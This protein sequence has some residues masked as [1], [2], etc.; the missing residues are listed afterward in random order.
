[1]PEVGTGARESLE[2]LA[3]MLP[4][5]LAAL[6][7]D[8]LVGFAGLAEE[9]GRHADALRLAVAGEIENRTDPS[10]GDDSLAHRLG[11][12][13]TAGALEMV[14]RTSADDA[15]RRVAEARNLAKL[16]VLG[17]AVNCGAL[18]RAQA[19]EIAA[20]ILK[21]LR[22]ADPAKVQAACEHLVELSAALPATAV[23]EAAKAWASALD[24]D[25]VEPEEKA[26]FEKRFVTLGKA[27][28]GMVKLTGLLTVEQAATIRTLTDAYLNPRGGV[29]FTPTGVEGDDAKPMATTGLDE[30][31]VD[32]RSAKQ[33]RA[34]IFHM[35]FAAQARAADAP[36]MGGAHPTIL[37][38][39]TR[40]NLDNRTGAAS[41]DGESGGVSAKTA[42]RIADSGGYQEVEVSPTG[43]I[44]S[45]GVTK[46]CF[47][48]A[49]R[50]ALALRDKGCVI[51]GCTIPARWCEA[52][53]IIYWQDGGPTDVINAAL[54]CFFHHLNID[55]GPYELRIRDGVPEVRWVFGSHASAWVKAVHQPR[56]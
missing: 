11:S 45:L 36:T 23:V 30:P 2:R 56:R 40:E 47:T 17:A 28:D 24:P 19:A 29:T 32:T 33:K 9:V 21:T 52:H 5:S 51:P 35:V 27:K 44:L 20:P 12:K 4:V 43:E 13:N 48:P 50:R 55:D 1:M 49:Q 53:H 39:I 15:R 3:R 18:G 46:R 6:T 38:S 22:V 41:V 25:G 42:A 26:A 10:L 14:T 54:L 34:D 37:V 8:Q 7:D 31:P 16:P